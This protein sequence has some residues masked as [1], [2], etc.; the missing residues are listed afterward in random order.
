MARVGSSNGG[1]ALPSLPQVEV[2]KTSTQ[3]I[4][5]ARLSASIAGVETHIVCQSYADR[6]CVFASQV[7]KVGCLVS[8]EVSTFSRFRVFTKRPSHADPSD[9]DDTRPSPAFQLFLFTRQQLSPR[10]ISH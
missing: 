7:G 1:P 2:F 10:I 8:A 3:A 5:S 4:P 9:G 6:I